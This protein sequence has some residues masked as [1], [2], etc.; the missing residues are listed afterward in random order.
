[1]LEFS[2]KNNG[3]QGKEA[4]NFLEEDFKNHELF[5]VDWQRKENKIRAFSKFSDIMNA[6]NL[7]RFTKY[8]KS[9]I[10]YK[11]IRD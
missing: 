3:K 7:R 6:I 1:M 9:I 10:Q 5:L 11:V 8:Q 4:L 2:A